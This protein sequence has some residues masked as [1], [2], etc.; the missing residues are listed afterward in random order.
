VIDGRGDAF[1]PLGMY[2]PPKSRKEIRAWKRSGVN[3]LRCRTEE[4]LE[5]AKQI[6]AA[7]WVPV[8]MI[9]SSAMDEEALR[10]RVGSVADD[11]TVAVW[12]APDEPIW[13]ACR[14]QS[15][16]VTNRIWAQPREVRDRIRS[17]LDGVVQGLRR[18]SRI[19]RAIDPGGK[20]WLNE[21]A[22]SDQETLSRCLP[23]L[24]VVSYDYYPVPEDP[25]RGRQMHL[26]G[27]FTD[28]FRRT[29]TAK[30]VWVVEQAFTWDALSDA[31]GG[32]KRLI[33]SYNTNT[34]HPMTEEEAVA[35]PSVDV[36][37]FMAWVAIIHGASGL[38]WFGSGF[39]KRPSPLLENLMQV[40][41]ELNALQPYLVSSDISRVRSITDERHC[42]PV[43]G[44]SATV[45]RNNHG[46]LLA[47]VNEDYVDHDV[48]VR[49]FD[50][51]D[52]E[53]LKPLFGCAENAFFS[54]DGI[55]L[56]LKGHEVQVYLAE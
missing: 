10:Q 36:F 44:C 5:V 39:E 16:V 11:H 33:H 42:P 15:G 51:L 4:D 7:A 17:R 19:V 26:I 56:T 31:S 24:D 37:R 9:C 32:K 25:S 50:W 2:D 34:W 20:L 54:N 46:T 52:P 45:R 41:G 38:L 48:F 13:R 35:V 49:G 22:K 23:Y 6:G 29:A 55:T 21:A 12:E 18:G 53:E 3:L 40:V 30:E 8:P 1:F 47:V 14:L 27:G 43:L 28:R